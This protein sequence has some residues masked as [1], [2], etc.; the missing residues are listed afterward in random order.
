MTR[1]AEDVPL[2]VLIDGR[3]LRDGLSG[4]GQ[5]VLHLLRELGSMPGVTPHALTFDFLGRGNPTLRTLDLPG[6]GVR[7]HRRRLL[8]R[9]VFNGVSAY[10]PSVPAELMGIGGRRVLHNTYFERFAEPLRRTAVVSTIHDVCFLR[11]PELFSPV[12]LAASRRALRTQIERSTLLLAVSEFTKRELVELAGVEPERIRVTPLAATDLTEDRVVPEVRDK[13]FALFVGNVEP[14]K[15]LPRLLDGW[16]AAGLGARF[17]LVLVGAP[18]Y[19][20][21]AS[22]AAIA[23]SALE[24][25]VHLGYVSA[26]RKRALMAGAACFVYPSLYEGF[27]IPVLE[28]MH[29]GVPV[30]AGDVA[31]L[32]EVG[33]MAATFV[34]PLDPEAIGRGIERVLEDDSLR[35][36][37]RA[38]GPD[39]AQR[40]TW[41][42]TAELTVD[43]YHAA[44]SL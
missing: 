27:G 30:V 40:F 32:R 44:L 23:G 31:A 12:N 9:K 15:N 6:S 41:K 4:V 37:L 42:R 18:L 16:R 34:D 43:A 33:G 38:A 17:D 5:Y 22:M 1:S 11:M 29:A 24:G 35:A 28:A 10:I 21:E 39:A 8:H 14:R 7:E 13:P 26:A 19:L 36:R 3:P 2:D 20:Q 25:V